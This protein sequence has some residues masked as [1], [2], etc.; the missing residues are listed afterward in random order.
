MAKIAFATEAQEPVLTEH[1]E[2]KADWVAFLVDALEKDDAKRRAAV[3][4]WP[5]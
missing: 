1:A 5:S 3:T 2:P 4:D